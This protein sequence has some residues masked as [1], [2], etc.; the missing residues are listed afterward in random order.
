LENSINVH[1]FAGRVYA[2]AGNA[3][4]CKICCQLGA[5]ACINYREEDFEKHILQLTEVWVLI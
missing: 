1:E 4:K 2:T 3:K 5:D